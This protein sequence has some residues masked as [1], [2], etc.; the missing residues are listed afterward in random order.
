MHCML[1]CLQSAAAACCLTIAALCAMCCCCSDN[2]LHCVLL[3][4]DAALYADNCCIVC[5]VLL[6]HCLLSIVCCTAIMLHC[7][8]SAAAACVQC[9]AAALY[10]ALYAAL[11]AALFAICCCCLLL[12]AGNSSDNAATAAQDLR[13]NRLPSSKICA[14]T[15]CH[16]AR[17]AQKP[18]AIEAPVCQVRPQIAATRDNAARAAQDWS[19]TCAAAAALLLEA[20]LLA[21]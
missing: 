8:Q 11:F 5:N 21:D 17:S 14:E 13:R 12:A 3:D 2:V 1:H 20:A 15:V 16:R 6:L 9:A 19:I 18:S 4:N 10:A 7:V